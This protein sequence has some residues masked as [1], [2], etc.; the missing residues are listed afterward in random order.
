MNSTRLATNQSISQR[1]RK[2]YKPIA[3]GERLY[4]PNQFRDLVRMRVNDLI[5][6]D[7][8]QCAGNLELKKIAST[9]L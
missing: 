2:P 1:P 5:Q 8:T 7:M 9:F 6:P 3:T 4:S